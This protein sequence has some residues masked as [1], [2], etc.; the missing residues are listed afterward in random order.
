[1]HSVDVKQRMKQGSKITR[2]RN[3]EIENADI[4]VNVAATDQL[5]HIGGCD[6][7]PHI[8]L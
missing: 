5:L 2:F 8:S 6:S 7:C 4:R 1:M 3:R